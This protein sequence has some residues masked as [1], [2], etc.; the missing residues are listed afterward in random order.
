MVLDLSIYQKIRYKEMNSVAKQIFVGVTV[1]VLGAALVSWL[2]LSEN[3][4]KAEMKTEISQQ[5]RIQIVLK[6]ILSHFLDY[7]LN[8]LF[9]GYSG[10]L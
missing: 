3:S 8:Y 9:Q 10:L 5:K 2:G 4:S 6:K 1:T 7:Y